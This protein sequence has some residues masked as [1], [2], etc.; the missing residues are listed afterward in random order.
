[1]TT[2]HLHCRMLHGL[3]W[4][5]WNNPLIP[6]RQRNTSFCLCTVLHQSLHAQPG[7]SYFLDMQGSSSGI[8]ALFFSEISFTLTKW[9][10]CSS[11]NSTISA[12]VAFVAA[13]KWQHSIAGFCRFDFIINN[14]QS[15]L[16]HNWICFCLWLQTWIGDQISDC[17]PGRCLFSCQHKLLV[18]IAAGWYAFF[19]EIWVLHGFWIVFDKHCS[20]RFEIHH[21]PHH[22]SLSKQCK[23]SYKS[24]DKIFTLAVKIQYGTNLFL[25][26]PW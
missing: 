5:C 15:L 2:H 24:Y 21:L 4:T 13:F 8:V 22:Q 23:V 16:L 9:L 25:P 18:D 12:D 1:M 19:C 26:I 17:Q 6:K 3:S 11:C 20:W 14:Q 10:K 7:V